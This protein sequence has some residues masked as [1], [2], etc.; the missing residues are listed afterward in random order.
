METMRDVLSARLESLRA[1]IS[2]VS[3]G[4]GLPRIVGVTKGRADADAQA[5][6]EAGLL[7]LAENRWESLG[8]RIDFFQT[9]PSQPFFHFI[10]ALQRR[11][12]RQGYRPIYRVETIDRPS[13]L[14]VLAREAG[15]SGIRQEVLLELNL[16]GI[17]GRSGMRGEEAESLI[18]ECQAWP[19]LSVSG[20]LV[21]GP[22]P[23]N[24]E[25]SLAVFRQGRALFDRFFPDGG[26]TLSMGMTDDFR[27][28]VAAGS[29]EI[30]IGRYFFEG[31]GGEREPV[32]FGG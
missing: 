6:F 13:I 29:T 16:T 32:V 30:R 17:A 12:I 11:S 1:E 21:M 18:E 14:P 5:L 9:N 19:E 22:P 10:G 15:R 3:P 27:E 24:R 25:A 8:R 2:R 20:F 4:G 31:T 28:A 7:H 23:G 26:K